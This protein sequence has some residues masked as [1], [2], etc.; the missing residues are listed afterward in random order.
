VTG[1]AEVVTALS[2]AILA[3]AVVIYVVAHVLILR[4][5]GS[6]SGGVRRLLETLDRDARPALES[7]RR[8]ADEVS[9]VAI[10]ARSEAE[11]IAGTS[12]QIRKRVGRTAKAAEDRFI[13]FETL[14][15]LLQ[16]EVEDTVLD[17]AAALKTT[18]RGA[19]IFRTMKRTL[20]RRR[21]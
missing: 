2:T 19:G 4:R 14:L 15:D 11:A 9:R 8:T 20:L 7:V 17:V 6:L 1:W 13:E 3:L 18:R 21:R 16:D 12:K 5:L 10:L